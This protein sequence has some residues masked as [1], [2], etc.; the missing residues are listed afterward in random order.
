MGDTLE[1]WRGKIGCFSNAF[2]G[3]RAGNDASFAS[4]RLCLLLSIL[5]L[6]AGVEP[7]PGP[8]KLDTA[9]LDEI[10][11]RL[12]AIITEMEGSKD[13]VNNLSAKLD[14]LTAELG[15]KVAANTASITDLNVRLLYLEQANKDL[16][17]TVGRH[18][19]V[20]PVAGGGVL[21]D[22]KWPRISERSHDT[23]QPLAPNLNA[24]VKEVSDRTKRKLNVVLSG[25]K[26]ELQSD[27]D[28]VNNLFVNTLDIHVTVE[29][30]TRMGKDAS[31]TRPL[32]VKLSNEAEVNVA[33]KA[34]KLLRTT[35]DAY[36]C[37]SV[38]L[39][40]DLTKAQ[41]EEQFNLRQERRTR[42]AAG[43]TNLVIRDGKVQ[44]KSHV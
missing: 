23:H 14:R 44:P 16:L 34:A 33:L 9:K 5:L 21:D 18:S 8:P 28:V 26:P 2:Q 3:L 4:L 19:T 13:A 7:N 30:C 43:E 20:L 37:R 40:A 36:I 6:A 42:T 11:L 35:G 29:E 17:V 1:H 24:I 15:A 25:V 39:N 38:F 12:D 32:L 27:M 22:T 10:G 41:R 31:K